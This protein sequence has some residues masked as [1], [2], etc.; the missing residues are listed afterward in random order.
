MTLIWPF[1]DKVKCYEVNW[2]TIII[3]MY[4]FHAKFDMMLHLEDTTFWKSC[5]LDLTL[6][7]DPRSNVW[8]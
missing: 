1:N 2:K 5:Y 6:T 4:M 3:Y 8:R 7:G